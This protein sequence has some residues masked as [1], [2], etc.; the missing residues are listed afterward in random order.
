ML[1]YTTPSFGTC[2]P[3]N[4]TIAAPFASSR[5]AITLSQYAME[6]LRPFESSAFDVFFSNPPCGGFSPAATLQIMKFAWAT[7]C[8]PD[9]TYTDASRPA[10]VAR[11]ATRAPKVANRGSAVWPFSQR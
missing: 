5:P 3:K 1:K 2:W 8:S 10:E 9:A 11:Y 7:D 6:S 4:G